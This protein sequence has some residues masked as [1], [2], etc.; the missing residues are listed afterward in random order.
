MKIPSNTT[1]H[2]ELINDDGSD[3]YDLT[4]LKICMH[5]CPKNGKI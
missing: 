2:E 5:L 1:I 4:T 3:F